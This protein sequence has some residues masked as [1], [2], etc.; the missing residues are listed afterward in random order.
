MSNDMSKIIDDWGFDPDDVSVRIVPGDDGRDKVQ[1]RVDLGVLQMEMDGRP[2]GIRPEQCESWLEYYEQQQVTYDA[3]HPDSTP[4]MLKKEACA[5]LWREG[6]QYYHRYLSFWHLELHDLCERDTS[7]NLRLFAF[8][9]EHV[10]EEQ[11][12]MQFDQWRPYVLMMHT[13]AV[14]TPLLEQGR[15]GAGLAAI[16]VGIG[17]IRDFLDQYGQSENAEQCVELMD[18]EHWH[19][20]MLQLKKEVEANLPK[21]PV[22][23]LRDQLDTAISDEQFEEAAKLRDRIRLLL[24]DKE[25]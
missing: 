21:S 14:A 12:K 1:L 18:L 13:R 25:L 5:R 19:A 6:V 22:E 16:E 8:V 15:S 4:Y 7:R 23:I 24:E 2:D 10:S 11:H 17:D 20:E 9:C 3:E